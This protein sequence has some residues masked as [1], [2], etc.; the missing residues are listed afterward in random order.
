MIAR[1]ELQARFREGMEAFGGQLSFDEPLAKHTWYR[2]GGPAS[3][4]AV[5][6]S[7]ADLAWL[8][9]RL[10][11][12]EVPLF[13][14]GSGS[15]LLVSDDGFPGVVIKALRLNGEIARDGDH[16]RAGCG[17]AVSQLLKRAAQEGWGG[18]E[19]LTGIP[20]SVGGV[21]TMN[22]GTHLGE[23]RDRLVEVEARD[24]RTGAA[25]A[26]GPSELRFE[27][28]RNLFL[29][30]D[31]LVWSARWRITPGDPAA[32][33]ARI[34]ETLARRKA[35]QPIDRPSCG[36]VFKNPRAHGLHAWQVVDRLG[37]RGHRIGGAEFSEK[38]SNFI[39]NAGG[40]T[41]AD[42]RGLIELAKSRA[43]TELGVELEEEVHY[44]GFSP[45]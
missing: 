33:K 39:V 13:V 14:L 18:L 21:V 43:K 19:F 40:A 29:P 1:E 24:L 17:V 3:V 28:R 35:T 9:E 22:A 20:G 45:R 15:N 42:V 8:G 26:Y 41:A 2:I 34:D 25:R 16:V 31:A 7:A 10:R 44:V 37:L 12:P 6:K 36:S 30:K 38:H 23:A 5:P 4:L 27:Y 32:V 11:G